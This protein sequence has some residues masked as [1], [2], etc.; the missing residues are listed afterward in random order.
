MGAVDQRL[1][2]LSDA[3]NVLVV[4]GA[5]DAGDEV[6]LEFGTVKIGFRIGL[7]HKLA[8]RPI[9]KGERI[10]KYGA[11]IGTAVTSIAAGDHVHIHN[12]QSDYT[13]T[14]ALTASAENLP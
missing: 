14:F 10:V 3:D 11:P 8:R 6:R 2:L 5:L 7:G 4:R 12:V 9:A 1:L 13:P